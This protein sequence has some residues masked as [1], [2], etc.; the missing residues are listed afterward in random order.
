M[1]TKGRNHRAAEGFTTIQP[2]IIWQ[3]RR[4]GKSAESDSDCRFKEASAKIASRKFGPL[5]GRAPIIP[6]FRGSSIGR[7]PGC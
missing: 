1:T 2:Y 5:M 4:D 6:R 3:L 7:A